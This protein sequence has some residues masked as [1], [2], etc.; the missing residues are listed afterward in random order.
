MRGQQ[1]LKVE[2]S[3]FSGNQNAGIDQGSHSDPGTA[4]SCRVASSTASQKPAS[5]FGRERSKPSKSAPVKPRRLEGRHFTN[6]LT[7]PLNHKR[8]A[9]IADAVEQ[10][11]EGSC[12]S[13]CRSASYDPS[14]QDEP[15]PEI[16]PCSLSSGKERQSRPLSPSGVEGMFATFMFATLRRLA[17]S[18]EPYGRDG[19]RVGLRQREI[20]GRG[21]WI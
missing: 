16:L 14:L 10:V 7:A 21:D 6:R 17:S 3:A 5:G 9:A 4:G 20:D 11:G 15:Y 18:Q 13:G 19:L 8:L 2:L 1:G 12:R